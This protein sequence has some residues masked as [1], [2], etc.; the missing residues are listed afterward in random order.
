MEPQP[1]ALREG[2]PL[3]AVVTN[4]NEVFAYAKTSTLK[5]IMEPQPSTLCEGSPL[6][7]VF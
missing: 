5:N 2:S 4:N 6:D 1:S 3:D 7:D